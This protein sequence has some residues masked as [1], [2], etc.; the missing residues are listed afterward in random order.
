[1]ETI[2]FNELQKSYLIELITELGELADSFVLI[3]GQALP[4]LTKSP[5]M[6]KDIA[7]HPLFLDK[8]RLDI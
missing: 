6:T 4:Y 8:N 2:A 3:G 5:R 1:M 7:V